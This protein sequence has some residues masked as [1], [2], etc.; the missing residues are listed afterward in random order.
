M[1]KYGR[2][3]AELKEIPENE[4]VFIIRGKDVLAVRAI[5]AYAALLLSARDG[6]ENERTKLHLADMASDVEAVAVEVEMW[7]AVHDDLVRLPD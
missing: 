2:V 3:S 4:P 5:Q 6:A 1:N 7:Q